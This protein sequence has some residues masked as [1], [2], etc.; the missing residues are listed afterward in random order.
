MS[1]A[2]ASATDRQV[3][4]VANIA[5]AVSALAFL[6]S[7]VD[8]FVYDD[9]LLISENPY[10]QRLEFVFRGFRTHLWDVY[11]MGSG[12]FGLRYYRPIVTASY[13]LNWVLSNG[14]AW[15]FHLVNVLCHALAT[16]LATRIAARW[17]GSAGLGL[18]AGLLFALHPTRTE[19]V[20]WI[21]GRTDVFMALFAFAAIELAHAASRA[22]PRTRPAVGFSI[23]AVLCLALA[24]LSK[25]AAVLTALLVLADALI[26]APSTR[27]RR[28]GVQAA[29][30]FAAFGVAYVLVRDAVYPVRAH[31]S[32]ELTPLYGLFTVSAYAERILFP[33]PQTFFFRPAE[34]LA[35]HPHFPTP[36][37]VSGVVLV[38]VYGAL[39][40]KA[41]RVDRAAFVLFLAAAGS[42]GPLLNFTFT[43]VYVTTSDHFLYVPLFL[44]AAGALR[45]Y[46][47]RVAARLDERVWRLAFA[48]LMVVYAGV[49]AVR[50]L[51]YHDPLAFWRHEL[52]VN[53][54]NPV[55]LTAVSEMDAE[56]GE[57]AL[58]RD[59]V[60]KALS[61][62]SERYFLLAGDANARASRRGRFLG[63]E[64]SLTADGDVAKLE[65]IF[66]SLDRLL[67]ATRSPDDGGPLDER[68]LFKAIGTIGTVGLLA[69]DTAFVGTRIGEI[70]RAN[71]LMHAVPTSMLWHVSNPM[72]FV[73]L[74]ARLGDFTGARRLLALSRS[75]PPGVVSENSP[76]TLAE[77]GARL[78]SAEKLFR[79][80][81]H[82]PGAAFRI[83]GALALAEL[84]SYLQALR[85][86]RPLFE[87]PPGPES[88]G[89]L[90]VQ[91]LVS[92]RLEQEALAT[93][94]ALIGPERARSVVE[95]L[96]AEESPRVRSLPAPAEPSRWWNP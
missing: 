19:S 91:L 82:E 57:L 8:G 13:V 71:E 24:V 96:H 2:D 45:L 18:V 67:R 58:A 11:S 10:A 92:A 23:G 46:R 29:T 63:L 70:R 69:V 5:A 35:G 59:A 78:D 83:D 79:R 93:A 81:T 80:A 86:L 16:W 77:V 74:H 88:A 9:Q 47:D 27:E 84:G 50:V 56:A 30:L 95:R 12:G 54:D 73:L 62:S 33:W 85:L 43:K 20:I 65:R 75:P 32:F 60:V 51:D 7:L 37:V 87:P 53:P 17:T 94:T 72:N 15:T 64:A 39:L 52:D 42:L 48:G 34:E 68:A 38:A 31:S 44:G 22:R 40:W 26:A 21:S 36:S 28:R 14:A 4:R 61:P 6:P 89:P 25:E 66:A 55:A 3:L 1:P 90:Y 76:E 49:D 41:F